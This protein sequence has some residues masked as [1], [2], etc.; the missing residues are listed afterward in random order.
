MREAGSNF[1]AAPDARWRESS[2]A[3]PNPTC[4]GQAR[5]LLGNRSLRPISKQISLI[6]FNRTGA[7]PV[8]M[9][10]TSWDLERQVFGFA[11]PLAQSRPLTERA[12]YSAPQ[13][14]QPIRR[15]AHCSRQQATLRKIP[16]GNCSRSHQNVFPKLARPWG[17][18]NGADEENLNFTPPRPG[19]EILV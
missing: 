5:P 10:K 7:K 14:P 11:Y 9:G 16:A 12:G 6:G 13:S 4:A 19:S 8:L 1:A 17:N 3:D 18:S 15:R 2:S